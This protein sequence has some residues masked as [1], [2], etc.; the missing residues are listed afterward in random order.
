MQLAVTSSSLPEVKLLPAAVVSLQAGPVR[1]L[2]KRIVCWK[3]LSVESGP[4]KLR[5]RV[6]GQIFTKD[7]AVG[8]GFMPTSLNRPGLD[9]TQLL[10]HPRE[11]PFAVNSPVQSIDIEYPNRDSW[12]CGTNSWFYYLLVMSLITSFDVKPLFN[13]NI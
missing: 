6:D 4:Q 3:F 7:L 11:A 2:E 1:V 8:A 9:L 10:M 13:V 5:F 12:T